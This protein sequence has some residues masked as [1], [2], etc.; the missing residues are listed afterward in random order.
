MVMP[1]KNGT[2]KSKKEAVLSN[3]KSVSSSIASDQANLIAALNSSFASIEFTP[4]GKIVTANTIFLD[5]IGYSLR[6]IKGKHHSMFVDK[7]TVASKSYQQFWEDLAAGDPQT[8]EFKRIGKGG[9][10][11]WLQASYTPVKGNSGKV[12]KIIKLAIDITRQKTEERNF[13]SEINRQREELNQNVEELKVA[14]EEV[15]RS[16]QKIQRTL[17]QA[18][19]AVITIDSNKTVTYWNKTAENIFGYGAGE[20]LGENVNQIVPIEHKEK[21]DNYVDNN[22][23]TGINKVIGNGRDL[24]MARKDG[25]KFWGNLSLSKVEMDGVVQYTAFIKDITKDREIRQKSEGIQAAVNTG[26]AYIE[27]TPEGTIVDANDNFL[28]TMGYQMIEIIGNHHSIFCEKEYASSQ[29]YSDFWKELANGNVKNND[30]KRIKKDGTDVWISA[31]Y[32]PVKNARGEVV[33]VIKIAND[34]TEQKLRNIDSEGQLDAISKSYGVI[35]FDM[36]GNILNA[37][38]NFQ[39]VV[40]YELSEIKGKHHR[41]F[42]DTETANSQQYADFWAKLNQGE[43]D[44]ASYRR[45]GK[46]GKEI[47]IQASYNPILDLNGVPFKVVKYATDITEFT[48]G[49]RSIST[50]VEHLRN[51]NFE[52][53]FKMFGGGEIGQLIEENLLTLRDTLNYILSDINNA[54]QRAGVEGDLSVRLDMDGKLG[55]WKTLAESI[56]SLILSF[57]EPMLEFNEI[58]KLMADG[59]LTSQFQMS[60][61]GE[62]KQMGDALNLALE[63]MNN[64]LSQIQ[65][66]IKVVADSSSNMLAKS[67]SVKNNANEVASAISQMAK[68]AQDQALK[69]DESSKLV[70]QVMETSNDMEEKA[71]GIFVT[72]EKGQNRSD[73][74]LKVVSNMVENMSEISTSAN[75]T[76][77]SINVLTQRAEEIARTLNVITDIAAQTNLLALNAAIEAARAGDAGRGFAVVAEEIRKLAEDSRK[78]AV[79][80]EKIIGDVQKDTQSAGKAIETMTTSVKEGNKATREA[81]GIFQE[82]ATANEQT[83]NYSKEIKHSTT[84]QKESIEY[85]VKNIEQIVVVAEETAAGTQQVASTSQQLN[86]SMEEITLSS[87]QL[88]EIATELQSGIKK[89]KLKK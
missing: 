31:S 69:T 18:I 52:E 55:S 19:D 39:K 30:F 82:I 28:N 27:F 11:L 57:A 14:Q 85:V 6:T 10:E 84:E 37:N 20:V 48:V 68:G 72:A 58:I 71:D 86:A 62:V 3:G 56:N 78:S 29:E 74:G 60:A 67:D 41:M 4:E 47:F 64:L 77:D 73:N 13:I 35:E 40:G 16:N 61:K 50:F 33:K 53:D 12:E 7:D 70:N 51:G 46:G 9:A 8:G 65:E 36:Q 76:S 89:F 87:N 5:T 22:L 59:D 66:S 2:S 79:D 34:V 21:L 88:A 83:L 32:T 25:T 44:S 75:L 24:E 23:E 43:F 63:N 42:V 81:E 17:D 26:W 45:I 80:I 49:L 54:V 15:E 1:E 38:E